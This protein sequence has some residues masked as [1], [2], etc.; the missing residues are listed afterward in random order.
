M[1]MF[2]EKLKN[3]N[4]NYLLSVILAILVILCS[5]LFI[6]NYRMNRVI[7][8]I[9][10]PRHNA[11]FIEKNFI[12]EYDELARIYKQRISELMRLEREIAS[13]DFFFRDNYRLDMGCGGC[14]CCGNGEFHCGNGNIDNKRHNDV[15]TLNGK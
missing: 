7:R 15:R 8:N 6:Q 13:R 10:N 12:G 9:Y 11:K 4:L 14:P 1:F 3:I 2:R 5:I